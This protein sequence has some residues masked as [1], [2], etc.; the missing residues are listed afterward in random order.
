MKKSFTKVFMQEQLPFLEL[1]YSNS[2]AHYK[3]HFHDTF[4]IGV[5]K[6]GT[7]VYR[8]ENKEYILKE[9][10]LSIINPN[11]VHSCNSTSDTLNEYYM[12]YLDVTWCKN[13]QNVIDNDITCFQNIPDD[14]LT[15]KYFYTEYIFL[16]EYL[17]TNHSISE[18]EDEM[19]NFYL[20]FFAHYLETYKEIEHNEVFK[21]IVTYMN[22]YYMENISLSELSKKFELNEF[23]IIRLFRNEVNLTP[24]SYLINIK[25]NKAKEFL[26]QGYSIVDTALECGFFDQSHF[27][28][29]FL[30]IVA[31]T[32]QQY[33]VNFVQ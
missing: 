33:Q 32:P 25:I 14:M 28:R 15:S 24:R 27:H 26:K 4:S 5:N 20:K 13:M 6:V 23:F 8:N 21:K 7:S 19:L 9:N 1:R 10:S 3:D 18:K 2:N 29:N 12:M 30:K 17:F 31:I 11:V 16:C 22:L